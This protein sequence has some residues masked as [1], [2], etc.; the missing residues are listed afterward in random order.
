MLDENISLVSIA[1]MSQSVAVVS[2]PIRF[3]AVLAIIAE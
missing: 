2:S 1:M 3:E